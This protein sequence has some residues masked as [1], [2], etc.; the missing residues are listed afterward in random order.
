MAEKEQKV[1]GAQAKIKNARRQRI[2]GAFSLSPT[3]KVHSAYER[4]F[5]T[6]F[7][8]AL[9]IGLAYLLSEGPFRNGHAPLTGHFEADK[10]L[11]SM[12]PPAFIGDGLIDYGI[13]IFIRGMLLL[14]LMGVGPLVAWVW[15]E[16]LDRPEMS[17]FRV[18]WA[19][20]IALGIA[21][22]VFWPMLTTISANFL[23]LFR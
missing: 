3:N 21:I 16:L 4:H 11:F 2:M 5:V 7:I 18:V 13:A 10:L 9:S 20:N 8:I 19:V 1:V 14:F 22:L 17:P 12:S 23:L 15:M 6:L